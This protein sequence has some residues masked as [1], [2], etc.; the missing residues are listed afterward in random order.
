MIP[1]AIITLVVAILVSNV[2]IRFFSKKKGEPSGDSG[3]GN[4]KVIRP[5]PKV[6]PIV[7]D[8]PTDKLQKLK[9][10]HDSGVLTNDEFSTA[11][12]KILED[13]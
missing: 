13:M 5:F 6:A 8:D 9:E 1:R 12:A 11:K 10:L 7:H 3:T 2:I 4:G